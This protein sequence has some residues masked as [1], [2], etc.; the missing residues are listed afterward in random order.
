MTRI[1]RSFL[2]LALLTAGAALAAKASPQSVPAH[3][4]ALPELKAVPLADGLTLTLG[5][6]DLQIGPDKVRLRTYNGGLIGPTLR[7]KPGDTLD[8]RL[9][10]TLPCLPGRDCR[11]KQGPA[12]H[13]EHVAMERGSIG[14]QP[15]PSV[16]NTTNLHT[17]GLHVSPSGNSDNVLMSV[18]PG[19]S[20]QFK[21]QVPKDHP[22]GTFWYHP[23]VHG[24]TATQ[25]SSG[26]E[27]AL[28]VEGGLD[29][30]PEIRAAQD[31][32]L[33]FQQIPYKCKFGKGQ[34][35]DWTCDPGQ[36][37]VVENFDQQFGPGSW[38]ASGRFTTINGEIQ[39]VIVMQP[40]EVQRWRMIHGGV[41]ETLQLGVVGSL[42][43]APLPG[44]FNEIALDGLATGE[45]TP[46]TQVELEPGYRD[47]VMLKAPPSGGTFYLIDEKTPAAKSLQVVAE[48][49]KVLAVIKVQG[50][51][52]EMKL[53]VSAQLAR[54]KPFKSITDDEVRGRK[55]QEVV[56][57][58]T[59]TGQFTING[60][61]FPGDTRVL[62]LG[63][64]DEWHL[65]TKVA[66][67]PFHIHV[68]PF[69]VIET[70]DGK[71][72]RYWKDTLLVKTGQTVRLRSRYETFDGAFVLH[73][74]ILDH[75][76]RGMMQMVEI[77]K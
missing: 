51:V 75:E 52:H 21:F 60:K 55:I 26:A 15:V 66:N 40:G 22:A 35:K 14:D 43:G 39:P 58:I 6:N 47:D 29:L 71:E 69:E 23:H 53:P 77:K 18:E 76:D 3:P 54:F 8:V 32:I 50:P 20:F 63:K 61:E 19:C 38:Q 28:I 27:G 56:F 33:L 67:H 62:E 11:C 30:V 70:V 31:R 64:A 42:G 10:N 57:N 17:H 48:P 4:P 46:R 34:E 65:T 16:F 72:R 36:T 7:V 13:H 12:L 44:W 2:A 74:H 68:N 59:Q 49:R 25:V 1:I 73:C 37:G 5:Y 41:R 24:S 45:I 9:V